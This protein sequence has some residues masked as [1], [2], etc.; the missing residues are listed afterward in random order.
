MLRL[1]AR[2]RVFIISLTLETSK[3]MNLAVYL[4]NAM[5]FHPKDGGSIN[6]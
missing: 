4:N 6:I 5:V 3:S 1:D 2:G